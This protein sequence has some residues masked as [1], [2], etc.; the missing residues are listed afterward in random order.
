MTTSSRRR[1]EENDSM[2][3]VVDEDE[4]PPGYGRVQYTESETQTQDG[5]KSAQHDV[6]VWAE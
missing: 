6:K 3:V 5:S 1:D 4:T 2:E